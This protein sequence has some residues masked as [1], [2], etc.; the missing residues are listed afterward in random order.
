MVLITGATGFVGRHLAQALAA[1]G[2]SLTALTRS[3]ERRN[4]LPA[5]TRVVIGDVNDPNAIDRAL[6]GVDKVIHLAASLPG[7]PDAANAFERDVKAT[8]LLARASR[9]RGVRTFLHLSSAG[10]YGAGSAAGPSAED[11][12]PAAQSAYERAKLESEQAVLS[13][14][15]GGNTGWVILRPTGIYGPGR[16]QTL[17]F[18]REVQH[19]AVWLHGPRRTIVHP[20]HVDDVVSACLSVLSRDD[21]NGEVFNIGGEQ[22]M[23]YQTLIALIGRLLPCRVFQ[24]SLPAVGRA[25][26]RSVNSQKAYERL[27]VRP[28]PLFEGMT[29]CIAS[30]RTERLL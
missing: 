28:K 14:L 2:S 21:V 13:E 29:Q 22:S 10:V 18:V 15:S 24:V 4:L 23:V 1:R 6:E 16:P 20:T 11:T 17:A 5:G 25:I 8:R 26:D 9:A 30:F 27:G 12:P 19:K 3:E 7:A